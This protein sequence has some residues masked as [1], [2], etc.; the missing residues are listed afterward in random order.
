MAVR[1]APRDKPRPSVC[2]Q[3]FVR[4]ALQ[5][6]DDRAEVALDLPL[7]SHE[8]IRHWKDHLSRPFSA[9][10]CAFPHRT[11]ADFSSQ[12]LNTEVAE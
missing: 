10:R 9:L 1:D 8:V 11:E 4:R 3:F 5:L 6:V 12:D 7:L 2:G